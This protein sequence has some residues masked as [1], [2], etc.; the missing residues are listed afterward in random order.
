[1][2]T[3]AGWKSWQYQNF[4]LFLFHVLCCEFQMYM[5]KPHPGNFFLR[6][7]STC[8]QIIRFLL[9]SFLFLYAKCKYNFFYSRL[10]VISKKY[11]YRV[12]IAKDFI[13]MPILW[14]I[15]V[16]P[17]ERFFATQKITLIPEDPALAQK[18]D[19]EIQN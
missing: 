15:G 13:F 7:S 5:N 9:F 10:V 3:N 4:V 18:I 6:Y 8:D 16:H 2:H 17:F 1:M 14:Y 11:F 12:R 19:L